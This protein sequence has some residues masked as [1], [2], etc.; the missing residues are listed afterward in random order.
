MTHPTSPARPPRQR[1][2]LRIAVVGASLT[3]PAAALLLHQAGLGDV[4][5]YDATPAGATLGGGVL[6]L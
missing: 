6:S 3:G 5:L 2:R 1:G 4:R